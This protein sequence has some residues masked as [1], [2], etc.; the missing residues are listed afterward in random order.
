MTEK[1]KFK[2]VFPKKRI[3]GVTAYANIKD[4]VVVKAKTPDG[5]LNYRCS[6]KGHMFRG[7]ECKHIKA[8]K[9]AWST[10]VRKR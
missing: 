5:G 6:C 1:M 2:V 8:F 7:E 4:Y 3:N 10:I 9:S